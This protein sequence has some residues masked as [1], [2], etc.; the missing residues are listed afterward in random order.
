MLAK[1]A[2]IMPSFIPPLRLKWYPRHR[3]KPPQERIRLFAFGQASHQLKENPLSDRRLA[4]DEERSDFGLN[5]GR[6]GRAERVNPDGG[7]NEIHEAYA[8]AAAGGAA[9]E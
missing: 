2:S 4:I 9:R 6:T 8:Y 7:V 5:N 1:S 3:K